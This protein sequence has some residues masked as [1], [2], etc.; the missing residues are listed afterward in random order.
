M[1][2]NILFAARTVRWVEYEAPLRAALDA[3]GLDYVLD[4]DLP[5]ETV[6]YIVYAPNSKVQDFTPYT[7]LK[8]VLNLWAG[9]ED[10]VNNPTL[11]V[12]FARMVDDAGLTQGMVEWVTGH[13][14]RHHLG[15]DAHIVNPNHDW[16]ADAPPVAADRPVGILGLG[17]LGSAC[18]Q[19]LQ[20]LGFPVTGWA[21]SP[22]TVEGI[23]CLTG[24]DGLR[25]VLR[26]SQIVVL[27]LPSTPSTEN[28]LN[29]ET[30]ALMPK[31]AFVVNPGRGPLID[32]DALLAALDS[33]HI[34]HATLDVFRTEPLPKDH[35]YWSHPRVTVTPHIASETRAPSASRAIVENIR[36]GEAGEPFLYLVDRDAGY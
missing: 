21:R 14:L 3:V 4:V 17:E 8:A 32:D 5:P 10:A 6:D 2:V 24:P 19:A 12:P 7:R 22:K 28:T 30:L 1:P 13:V 29:A 34:A 15:M 16:I 27:L 35:P 11:K 23:P 9:V 18:G 31:G 25:E 33:G 36:R 26:Q 20:Q